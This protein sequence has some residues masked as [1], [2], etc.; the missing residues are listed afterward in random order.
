[1]NEFK[2]HDR[3]IFLSINIKYLII[4]EE[5]VTNKNKP[6]CVTFVTFGED[7]PHMSGMTI[8]RYDYRRSRINKI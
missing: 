2:M 1:V 7:I 4:D 8:A 6:K 3:T 5:K